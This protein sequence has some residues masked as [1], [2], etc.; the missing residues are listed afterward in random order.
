MRSHSGTERGELAPLLKGRIPKRIPSLDITIELTIFRSASFSDLTAALLRLADSS[1]RMN[2]STGSGV[3][4]S[5]AARTGVA[6]TNAKRIKPTRNF[7][8]SV[9]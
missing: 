3:P 8:T 5:P 9:G 6:P 4:S 1:T 2:M 7:L